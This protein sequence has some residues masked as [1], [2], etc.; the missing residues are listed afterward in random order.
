MQW[1]ESRL[2]FKNLKQDINLNRLLPFEV[3]YIWV[4]ELVFP[5]TEERTTSIVD[6]KTSISVERHGNFKLSELSENENI[7]NFKGIENPLF[8]KRYYNQR[9]LCDYKLNWYPFDI[10][11]CSMVFEMDKEY[12]PFTKFVLKTIEYTGE[13]TM[14]QYHFVGL[15]MKLNDE[16]NNQFI[17]QI[18]LGRQL[19]GIILKIFFPT[20]ILNMISYSTNFYREQDFKTV[21]AMNLTSMLVIV[22][23]FVSVRIKAKLGFNFTL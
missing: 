22:T 2:R 8:M 7:Q 5:N 3:K 17:I 19:F 12:A 15:G 13:R 16:D 14:P 18:K 11:H 21:M 9:F 6:D 20:I 1:Y 10:Q 23:L 4:P